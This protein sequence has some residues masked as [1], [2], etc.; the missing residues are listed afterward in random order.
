MSTMR[1]WSSLY[2]IQR[3][4]YN[5]VQVLVHNHKYR[6]NTWEN[7]HY[8]NFFSQTGRRKAC[9]WLRA[10]VASSL[11]VIPPLNMSYSCIL[12]KVCV[13]GTELLQW[14]WE[15]LGH[16]KGRERGKKCNLCAM[17]YSHAILEVYGC[18]VMMS[19]ILYVTLRQTKKTFIF[20]EMT[21]FI[22][23]FCYPGP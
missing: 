1:V 5:K 16:L 6:A 17:D 11:S 18:V 8:L 13:S 10:R 20:R 4:S 12:Q 23:F 9:D 2:S 7:T 14:E 19:F 3:P 15:K 21:F 22:S